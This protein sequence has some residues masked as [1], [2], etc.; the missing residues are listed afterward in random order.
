MSFT[1][2]E[3][4]IAVFLLWIAWHIGLILG[5]Y[6]LRRIRDRKSPPKFPPDRN[7]KPPIIIDT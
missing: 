2:M 1:L 3:G 7:D 5:P 6:L 4:L